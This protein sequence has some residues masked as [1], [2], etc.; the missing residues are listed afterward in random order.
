MRMV[1]D[2]SEYVV[3][4]E[5]DPHDF[6]F[7]ALRV[8]A[9]SNAD[10]AEP[11]WDAAGHSFLV[12]AALT[13]GTAKLNLSRAGVPSRR[14]SSP[15][16]TVGSECRALTNRAAVGLVCTGVGAL[17]ARRR[18]AWCGVAFTGRTSGA[19]GQQDAGKANRSGW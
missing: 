12:S 3:D 4:S 18:R 11:R 19:C 16:W 8:T 14:S 5:G 2:Q 1:R 6:G 7:R 15:A 9:V 13:A 17:R 10:V